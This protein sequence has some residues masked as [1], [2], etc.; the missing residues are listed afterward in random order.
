MSSIPKQLIIRPYNEDNIRLSSFNK[1][2]AWNSAA[3]SSRGSAG[4]RK[5]IDIAGG[6]KSNGKRSSTSFPA[7]IKSVNNPKKKVHFRQKDEVKSD[8]GVRNKIATQVKSETTKESKQY[9]YDDSDMSKERPTLSVQTQE[10]LIRNLEANSTVGLVKNEVLPD[11]SVRTSSSTVIQPLDIHL[12][13]AKSGRITYDLAD[14]IGQE[15]VG[16]RVTENSLSPSFQSKEET[17]SAAYEHLSKRFRELNKI[18]YISC[19]KV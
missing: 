2:S 17:R 8:K 6:G 10:E 19:F 7:A 11:A 18:S 16:K 12:L 9:L 5:S 3:D 14:F 4:K 1:G 15:M 13:R